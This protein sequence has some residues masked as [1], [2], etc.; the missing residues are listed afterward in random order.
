MD[1]TDLL[2]RYDHACYLAQL[3]R[4]E[5]AKQELEIVIREDGTGFLRSLS[6][7]MRI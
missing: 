7:K 5:E 2:A 3:N 1:A 4:H 6:R